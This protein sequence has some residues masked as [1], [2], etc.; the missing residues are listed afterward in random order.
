MIAWLQPLTLGFIKISAMFF[1]R[2][3]F[4]TG[5]NMI[6]NVTSWVF[7]GIVTI[8]AFSFFWSTVFICDTRFYYLWTNLD[9]QAK[10]HDPIAEQRALAISDLITDAG[11]LL[12]PLPSIWQLQMNIRQKA[13]VTGIFV[14]GA[15]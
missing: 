3:I 14:I 8:W 5:H 6:L 11:I 10:C 15:A 4:V 13:A 1:Y 12:F 7:I 9:N 2:R